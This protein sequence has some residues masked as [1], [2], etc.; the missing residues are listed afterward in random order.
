M[1]TPLDENASAA[2]SLN[3]IL[4]PAVQLA[5]D[6]YVL[7]RHPTSGPVEQEISDDMWKWVGTVATLLAKKAERVR[8]QDGKK[9]LKSSVSETG[10]PRVDGPD[11]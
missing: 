7:A 3:G 10:K 9:E 11:F 5:V 4:N 6:A 2:S 8:F 1:A